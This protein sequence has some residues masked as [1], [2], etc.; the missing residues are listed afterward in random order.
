M[1]RESPAYGSDCFRPLRRPNWS[2][3]P[4]RGSP[5]RRNLFPAHLHGQLVPTLLAP[6]SQ[7]LATRF[8]GHACTESMLVQPLAIPGIVRGAH[9]GPTRVLS[10]NVWVQRLAWK[11][12]PDPGPASTGQPRRDSRLTFPQSAPTL[13]PPWMRSGTGRRVHPFDHPE[14]FVRNPHGGVP[15]PPSPTWCDQSDHLTRRPRVSFTIDRFASPTQWSSPPP[16][17]GPRS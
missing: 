10:G 11:N 14:A 2:D 15:V 1:R 13:G 9:D 6:A 12:T 17:C 16:K 7:G 5:P 4:P 3:R 8:G